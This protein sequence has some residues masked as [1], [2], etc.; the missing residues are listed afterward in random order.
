MEI[1][2]LAYSLC[3]REENWTWRLIDEMGEVVAGGIAPDRRSAEHLALDAIGRAR[4]R[5]VIGGPQ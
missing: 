2:P 1:Y 3:E 5:G 4:S